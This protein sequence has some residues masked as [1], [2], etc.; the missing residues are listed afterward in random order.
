MTALGIHN[1]TAVVLTLIVGYLIPFLT[2]LIA[3][4]HWSGATMG[5]VTTVLAAVAGFFGEWAS[6]PDLS[7]YDWRSNALLAVAALAVALA[8][9]ALVLRGT[10]LDA[11][12]L[13]IGSRAPAPA[14]EHEAA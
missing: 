13:A 6:S 5:L 2:S 3:K 11:K 12:L 7:H 1:L 14:P 9:R 10:P 8:S 4:Q